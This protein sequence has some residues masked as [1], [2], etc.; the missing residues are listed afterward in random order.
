MYCWY[1]GTDMADKTNTGITI[2]SEV[3]QALD[4]EILELKSNHVVKDDN[5]RSRFLAAMIR[6][7]LEQVD[8]YEE[9]VRTH[10]IPLREGAEGNR[11]TV[12]AD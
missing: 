3:L 5:V 11:I 2:D 4:D 12:T 1:D 10:D 9:W 6:D 8:D 7:W